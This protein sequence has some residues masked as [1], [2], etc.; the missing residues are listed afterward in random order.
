MNKD[1]IIVGAFHEVVELC[2][3]CGFNIIGII[4]NNIKG[5]Y[6]KIPILGT[7]NDISQLFKIYSHCCIVISPDSPLLR[8]KL[9]KLYSQVGFRFA[10]VISPKANISRYATI[11]EGTIVQLGANVSAG[12]KIGTFVK[13]NTNA[14]IMH[15]N[16]V[17][18]FSTIAPNAVLLDM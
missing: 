8:Q 3:D 6:L 2:E 13:I 11:G 4:D 17:G 12:T 10:T 9:F 16:H 7:D 1:I 5:E 18:N 15:D 14:N